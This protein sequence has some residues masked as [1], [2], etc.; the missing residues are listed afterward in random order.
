MH[1]IGA[2]CSLWR[3]ISLGINGRRLILSLFLSLTPGPTFIRLMSLRPTNL[4]ARCFLCLREGS[5]VM[6]EGTISSFLATVLARI[7]RARLV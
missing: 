5:P 6:Q 4:A 2:L 1:D 7:E 3:G